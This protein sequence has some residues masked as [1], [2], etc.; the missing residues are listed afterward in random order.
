LPT[1]LI[2]ADFTAVEIACA[3]QK[4]YQWGEDDDGNPVTS[5]SASLEEAK[6]AFAN[7][8][9]KIVDRGEGEPILCFSCPSRRYFRHNL[10]PT[11]K[12][13]RK[14]R[15]APIVL[16]EL[17]AWA[18]S[19]WPTKTKPNLE[20]DDVLGILATHPKFYLG[21]CI[22][23]SLD[24]DLEQI[25]GMHMN[26]NTLEVYRVNPTWANRMLAFQALTGD[27][28][29]NYPGCPKI[30][31]KRAMDIIR[32][33]PAG[34]SY[35]PAIQAAYERA[36]KTIEEMAVQFN[37]ARILNADTYN[38]KTGEPILWQPSAKA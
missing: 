23:V 26:P 18:S 3:V 24:K 38:F 7:K 14:G 13:N 12:A 16:A 37:V 4:T 6:E 5:T 21:K 29:D 28:T 34:E 1:L 22:I 9:A 8:I 32:E 36:G 11:Y 33:V 17:K 20:A 35:L 31:P 25:P 2:D 19:E 30:G 27:S 15:Q 10:W